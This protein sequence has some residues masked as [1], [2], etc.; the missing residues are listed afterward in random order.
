MKIVVTIL[1]LMV[2]VGFFYWLIKDAKFTSLTFRRKKHELE[3]ED[4][5]SKLPYGGPRINKNQN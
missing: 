5:Q 2:V 4:E 1:M 3:K